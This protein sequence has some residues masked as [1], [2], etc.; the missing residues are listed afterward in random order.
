MRPL[1]S[2]EDSLSIPEGA[3]RFAWIRN[4][5]ASLGFWQ[6]ARRRTVRAFAHGEAMSTADR[7][8]DS[9]L[10]TPTR[11]LK[12]V[13]AALDVHMREAEAERDRH[14]RARNRLAK[15]VYR[16]GIPA[17][18]LGIAAVSSALAHISTA[19]TAAIAIASAAFAAALTV[20][21][22]AEGRMDHGRKEADYA[23]LCRL[24]RLKSITLARRSEDEQLE[25]LAAINRKRH[26]LALRDPVRNPLASG[27]AERADVAD[28]LAKLWDLQRAGALTNEEFSSAKQ[29]LLRSP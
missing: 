21:S 3:R 24:I 2:A 19:V 8:N 4:R 16:L 28:Q 14:R 1:L 9:S 6:P 27:P 5:P 10:V 25:I 7:S 17:G 11:V 29:Q 20:V 15:L 26:E 18:A 22:P 13:E 23:D 12:D